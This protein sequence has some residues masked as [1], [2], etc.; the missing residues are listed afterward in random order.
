MKISQVF[1]ARRCSLKK[2]KKTSHIHCFRSSQVITRDMAITLQLEVM[3]IWWRQGLLT[4]QRF[5]F[6]CSE[7]DMIC[8]F[9]IAYYVTFSLYISVLYHS[10]LFKIEVKLCNSI[11][12]LTALFLLLQRG[13]MTRVHKTLYTTALPKNSGRFCGNTFKNWP[14]QR[15]RGWRKRIGAESHVNIWFVVVGATL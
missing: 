12:W 15:K 2:K 8:I 13:E 14:L 1:V 5:V 4:P 3:R 9:S 11:E 7:Y 10:L 6:H